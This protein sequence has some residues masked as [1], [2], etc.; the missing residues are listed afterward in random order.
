MNASSQALIGAIVFTIWSLR[1]YYKLYDQ[2]TKRYVMFIGYLIVF[3]MLIRVLNGAINEPT[4][5]RYARY[6]YYLPLIFI[7]TFFYIATKTLVSK[8]NKKRKILLH[9]ISTLMLL[10]V[11]TNDFH[12]FAF[13]YPNGLNDY[14]NYTHYIGYYIVCVYMFALFVAGLLFIVIKRLKIKRDYKA[15]IPLSFVVLLMIYTYLYIRDISYIRE[16]D[17]A[18]VLSSLICIEV[19]LIFS[20]DLLPNNSKYKKSFINSHLD[21]II[22]SFDGNNI[23]NTLSFKKV[24]DDILNDIRNKTV[25]DNYY[26]GDIIY[27]IRKTKDSYVIFKRNVKELNEI[28]KDL[29]I[30]NKQLLKQQNILKNEEKVKKE[31]YEITLKREIALNLEK[32]LEKYIEDAKEMIVKKEDLERIKLILAYAKRKS[33]LIISELNNDIYSETSIKMLLKELLYD[34][35]NINGEIVVYKMEIDSY[36]MSKI[37]EIIFNILET[38]KDTDIM[39]FIKKENNLKI[40]INVDTLIDLKSEE[41]LIKKEIIDNTTS[42]EYEV[43]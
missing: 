29:E 42:L 24:P 27:S 32:N 16:A 43:H 35:I 30:K 23:Y 31:L 40:T 18:L 14:K 7:P 37:Y 22:S 6:F 21:V 39:I 33:S 10:L 25:K 1:L 38:I 28:K 4:F 3:W 13:K 11:L 19:E 15:L 12:Q 20:L 41:Y 26:Q 2:K 9:I 36:L 5:S 17:L 34:S 8:I